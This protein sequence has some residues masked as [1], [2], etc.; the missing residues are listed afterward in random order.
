M[1]Q[2]NH[3]QTV[4]YRFASSD[5]AAKTKANKYGAF[6]DSLGDTI[7][8]V[9]TTLIQSKNII[10]IFVSRINSGFFT[11]NFETSQQ[12]FVSSALTHP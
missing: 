12:L 2:N 11:S 3:L 8:A 10:L 5:H 6:D 1:L 9:K 4:R 7:K